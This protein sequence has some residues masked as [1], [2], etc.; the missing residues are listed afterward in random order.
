MKYI[1]VFIAV[2]LALSISCKKVEQSE[3]S[4]YS[5]KVFD[6]FNC[7]PVKN[8]TVVLQHVTWP[9]CYIDSIIGYTN[10]QGEFSFS[11]PYEADMTAGNYD[12]YNIYFMDSNYYKSNNTL[13]SVTHQANDHL[14][15]MNK[16]TVLG[17]KIRQIYPTPLSCTDASSYILWFNFNHLDMGSGH[18]VADSV[19]STIYY[20]YFALLPSNRTI[21][22]SWSTS[23]GN[24]ILTQNHQDITTG[25]ND[26]TYFYIDY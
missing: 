23:C 18:I 17:L 9:A 10:A 24:T 2:I 19:S 4:I 14:I 5:F 12:Y 15:A 1:S 21:H 3:P 6:E 8:C 20:E 22:I 11:T 13:L 7:Q 16:K 26:T 25:Y